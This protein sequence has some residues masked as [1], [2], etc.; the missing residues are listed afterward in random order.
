MEAIKQYLVGNVENFKKALVDNKAKMDQL[1]AEF[2]QLGQA[3]IMIEKILQ[4]TEELTK[5]QN[6]GEA[7][8]GKTE[9]N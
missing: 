3:N 1:N 4:E 5:T 8:G 2:Q 6:E 7:N 9:T